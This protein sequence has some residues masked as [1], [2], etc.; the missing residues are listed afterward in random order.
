MTGEC[1]SRPEM[2]QSSQGTGSHGLRV[3]M[4][5]RPALPHAGD[6]PGGLRSVVHPESVKERAG[7]REH[8]RGR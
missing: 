1:P 3:I 6:D 7:E 8:P 4:D 2:A 5:P